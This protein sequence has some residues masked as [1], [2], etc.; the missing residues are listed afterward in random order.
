MKR[1]L[2]KLE[3]FTFDFVAFLLVCFTWFIMVFFVIKVILYMKTS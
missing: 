3:D 2:K 1:F